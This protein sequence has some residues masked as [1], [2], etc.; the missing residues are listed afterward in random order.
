MPN[1]RDPRID[2]QPGDQIKVGF[3]TYIVIRIRS[4]AGHN[5]IEYYIID[6]CGDILHSRSGRWQ[7]KI[8]LDEWRYK[9][10]N[11]KPDTLIKRENSL[12]CLVKK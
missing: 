2:P 4:S 9:F 11:V 12:T 5:F 8:S 3:L 1:P 6:K 7:R 10:E